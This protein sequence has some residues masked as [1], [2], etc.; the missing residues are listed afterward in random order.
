VLLH[1]VAEGAPGRLGGRRPCAVAEQTDVLGLHD[2][3]I[4]LE[5]RDRLAQPRLFV[6]CLDELPHALE[7]FR[8]ACGRFLPRRRVARI[9]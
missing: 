5:V 9:A 2:V 1:H 3:A 6:G 4:T 7:V 8:R